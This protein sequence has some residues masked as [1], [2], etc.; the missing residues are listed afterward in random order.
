MRNR[1]E[2][3]L[4]DA[5]LS[6]RGQQRATNEDTCG[7]FRDILNIDGNLSDRRLAQRRGYLFVVADG[8]GGHA[9]GEIA[10]AIAI[11]QICRAYYSGT[12]DDPTLALY[13]AFQHANRAILRAAEEQP[14]SGKRPMGTTAVCA[15]VR[16][17]QLTI[18]HIGDSR[19][20]M[21]RDGTLHRLTVDHNWAGEQHR[22]F[23][24]LGAQTSVQP[25]LAT[26]DWQAHDVLLLCS[27]GLHSQVAEH[28][29]ARVLAES[30]PSLA[31]RA[32]VQAANAA[33]GHDNSTSLVVRNLASP[34]RW[35]IFSRRTAPR[36]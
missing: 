11:E 19:A 4:D 25:E 15:V 1:T 3:P 28:H 14:R 7:S 10:S 16:D 35:R 13:H 30:P 21:L 9:H 6:H 34:Q 8:M 22:L 20:Y 32:L 2:L 18:G 5:M 29:I 24:A 31:A 17:T 26:L 36:R 23:R 12:S 27:D 33:G